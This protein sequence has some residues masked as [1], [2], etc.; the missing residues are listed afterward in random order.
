[1]FHSAALKLTTWY[2]AIIMALSI[3]CSL[4]IYH[5][6]SNA[7]TQ[8]T[9][10]QIRYFNTFLG[11][12]D[13]LNYGQLRDRQL[14]NDRSHLRAD[15]LLFNLLVLVGG[16]AISY[17]LARRTLEPIEESLEAQKRFAADASHELR[18]PLT[19]MQAETEVGLRDPKL[20]RAGAIKLLESNLEELSKLRTL[21][22]GLL[23]LANHGGRPQAFTAVSMSAVARAAQERLDKAAKAKKIKISSQLTDAETFGDQQ[24]LTDLAAILLDNAIKFSSNGQTV[25]IATGRHGKDAYMRVTDHGVG[26]KAENLPYIFDRFYQADSSRHKGQPGG[27]GLGLAIARKI[28]DL[29]GGHIEVKSTLGQGSSF[30]IFLPR[31]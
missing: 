23:K 21:S 26:I 20:S 19:A 5:T 25:E 10:R 27:Y 2:L 18:T 7:L 29:H 28:A 6:S 17:A 31:S 9:T 22:E 14:A 13:L 1:M 30:T 16:G 12:T 8:D 11:P 24:N 15:L 3:G 4:V